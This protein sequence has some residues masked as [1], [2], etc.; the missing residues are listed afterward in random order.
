MTVCHTAAEIQP[1]VCPLTSQANPL[2]G[3]QLTPADHTGTGTPNQSSTE[4]ARE[5]GQAESTAAACPLAIQSRSSRQNPG[6][7]SVNRVA[8]PMAHSQG[9]RRCALRAC[10]VGSGDA[11]MPESVESGPARISRGRWDDENIG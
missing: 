1:H 6:M 10:K 4:R 2:P 3:A 11:A 8:L 7:R 9:T 5:S